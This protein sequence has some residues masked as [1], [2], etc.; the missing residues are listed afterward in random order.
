ML[1]EDAW[2][3]GCRVDHSPRSTVTTFHLNCVPVKPF[4]TTASL[5]AFEEPP[6]VKCYESERP[7]MCFL[8]TL[9]L[10]N[11]YLLKTTP[12]AYCKGSDERLNVK[13]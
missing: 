12:G 10:G 9:L 8:C 1:D 7:G 4:E 5:K 6:E 2:L 3:A 11:L 13:I